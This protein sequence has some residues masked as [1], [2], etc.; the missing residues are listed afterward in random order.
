MPSPTQEDT[1]GKDNDILAIPRVPDNVK[2]IATLPPSLNYVPGTSEVP[3]KW[4][5]SG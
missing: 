4:A 5:I 1:N 2:D 3:V